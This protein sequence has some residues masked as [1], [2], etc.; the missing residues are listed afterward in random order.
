MSKVFGWILGLGTLAG[1]LYIW[2]SKQNKVDNLQDALEAQRLKQQIA[3]D[4][5]TLAEML[6]KAE[7]QM[8]EREP[9]EALI[10]ES[11]NRVAEIM[12]QK[13]LAEMSEEEQAAAFKAAGF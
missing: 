10:L 11:K 8:H 2:W 7:I 6:V 9:I 1:A 13:P 3:K 4:N 5:A 12:A